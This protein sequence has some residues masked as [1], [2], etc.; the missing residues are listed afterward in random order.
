M[1]WLIPLKYKVVFPIVVGIAGTA[2]LYRAITAK[3]LDREASRSG[4]ERAQLLADSLREELEQRCSKTPAHP[5]SLLAL[6]TSEM[7]Y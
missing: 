2:V 3:E 5:C 4:L 1:R 7:K 6:R